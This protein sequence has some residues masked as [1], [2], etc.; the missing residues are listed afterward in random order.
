MLEPYLKQIQVLDAGSG[1][2]N[3]LDFD[4]LMEISDHPKLDVQS[5]IL[6]LDSLSKVYFNDPIFSKAAG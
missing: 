6:L 5:A 2:Y 3:V 1:H 4:F